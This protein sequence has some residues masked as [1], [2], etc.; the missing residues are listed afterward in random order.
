MASETRVPAV[1]LALAGT[2]S[3]TAA[4][5]PLQVEQKSDRL[6]ITR[7]KQPVAEY[8]FADKAIL[9]PYFTQVHAPGGQQV[10]RQHPPRRDVDAVDH[11][12]MHP[13]IWLAFGDISGGDFWRNKGR[14]EHV[15]FAEPPKI[16]D[17]LLT[18][19]A[20]NRYTSGE[21]TLCK[22]LARHGLRELGGGYLLTF[23]S[24]F[25]GDAAFVFGDQEEMGLGAR[26][27]TPLAVKGGSGTITN[28]EGRKNEKEVWGRTAEWC[29]YSGT[30]D[31][32]RAGLL[33]VPHPQN[34]RPSWFHARD[35]GFVTAN[36]FGQKAF[37][38]GPPSRIEVKPGEK[39][40]LRYGIW[41]YSAPLEP[42]PD[43]ARVAR[44]YAE[45]SRE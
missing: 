20:E 26:L 27:A 21:R 44:H 18:F 38:K 41:T 12:T 37:T 39:L 22:E 24:E 33:V 30:I 17:G 28:S 23:D 9:R 13:G 32:R 35:Y 11:D 5:P 25:S 31:G 2:L 8:V 7:G 45:V 16:Q 4:E 34:F 43:H 29:D 40:R 10:T 1:I 36:P 3:L 15:R 14:V 19:A 42:S 6:I